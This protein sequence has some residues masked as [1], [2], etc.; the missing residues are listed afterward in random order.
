MVFSSQA[1][2][3]RLQNQFFKQKGVPHSAR[4]R[5]KKIMMNNNG[6]WKKGVKGTPEIDRFR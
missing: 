1:R 2:I 5:Q 3:I 6:N 4:G